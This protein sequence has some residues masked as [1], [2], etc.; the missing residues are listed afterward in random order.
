MFKKEDRKHAIK[1]IT[2]MH[3][4]DSIHVYKFGSHVHALRHVTPNQNNI[5]AQRS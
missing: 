5:K 2:Y 1:T 4:Q 3:V